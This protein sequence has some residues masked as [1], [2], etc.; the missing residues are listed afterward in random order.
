MGAP[1]RV[2]PQELLIFNPHSASISQ[3]LL[4]GPYKFQLLNWPQLWFFI[5]TCFFS[6]QGSSLPLWPQISDGSKKNAG[7]R[8]FHDNFQTPD[9]LELK[10]WVLITFH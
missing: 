1:L 9:M 8:I 7:F 10:L 2:G 5:D 6:F 4:K 3:L